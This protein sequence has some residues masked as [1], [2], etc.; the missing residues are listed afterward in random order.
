LLD[1]KMM[2]EQDNNDDDFVRYIKTGNPKTRDEKYCCSWKAC[3]IST[4]VTWAFTSIAAAV[5]F[6]VLIG[7]HYINVT[8]QDPNNLNDTISF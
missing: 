4:C 3:C 2:K 1:N 7:K 8:F 5:T 6:G